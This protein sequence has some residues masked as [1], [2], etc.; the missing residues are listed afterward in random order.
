MNDVERADRLHDFDLRIVE[1]LQKT[2][3]R[4]QQQLT[5]Y[6]NMLS[7][8]ALA[9]DLIDQYRTGVRVVASQ[10]ELDQK[11]AEGEKY[12]AGLKETQDRLVLT[13]KSNIWNAASHLKRLHEKQKKTRETED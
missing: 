4:Q 6:A 11:L 9:E 10:D 7:Q 13:M 8:I 5:E 3:V 2:N 12:L 1:V